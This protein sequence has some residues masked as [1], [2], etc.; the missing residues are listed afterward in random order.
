MWVCSEEVTYAECPCREDVNDVK[1]DAALVS[2]DVVC[3][4]LFHANLTGHILHDQQSLACYRRN[5]REVQ[6]HRHVTRCVVPVLVE[7]VKSCPVRLR[8]Q[9]ASEYEYIRRARCSGSPRNNGT[10]LDD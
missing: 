4:G 8:L 10:A 1:V 2:L 3:Y 7:Q 5:K 9:G 6:A